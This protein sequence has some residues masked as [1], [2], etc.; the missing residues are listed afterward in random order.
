MPC[1]VGCVLQVTRVG[2]IVP[3]E[4]STE[5]RRAHRL[6]NAWQFAYEMTGPTYQ[7]YLVAE[8]CL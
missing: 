1:H 3:R 2:A 5:F 4:L 7:R 6:T 8:R